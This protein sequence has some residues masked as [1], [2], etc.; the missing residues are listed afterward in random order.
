M[1]PF[2]EVE[3]ERV[4]AL[5]ARQPVLH[6]LAQHAERAERAIDMEPQAFFRGEVGQ[7]WDRIETEL[8]T[9]DELHYVAGVMPDAAG[10]AIYIAGSMALG[11]VSTRLIERLEAP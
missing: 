2:V 1:Q 7:L 6:P 5:D 10:F 8:G 4:G 11:I 3:G 9:I